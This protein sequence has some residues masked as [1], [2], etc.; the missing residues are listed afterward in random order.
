MPNFSPESN[1]NSL[2]PPHFP[3]FQDLVEADTE[4]VP[5]K[6]KGLFETLIG[7]PRV[8]HE[9]LLRSP[10]KYDENLLPLLQR[11]VVNHSEISALDKSERDL[12]NRAVYD[13]NRVIEASSPKAAPP[14]S[15]RVKPR[16]PESQPDGPLEV[17]GLKPYWWL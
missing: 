3:T 14:P 4:V 10:E 1:S 2:E 16:E 9:D 13:F 12:L 6:E 11:L 15:P 7:D 8:L 5:P 17:E